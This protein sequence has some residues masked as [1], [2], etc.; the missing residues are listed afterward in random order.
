MRGMKTGNQH[1][2]LMDS[3]FTIPLSIIVPAY[4]EQAGIVGSVRS[5]IGGMQY[6]LYEVIV[7]N[8]GSKDATLQKMIDEFNMEEVSQ[9]VIR[10]RGRLQS[11]KVKA[12]YQSIT[13]PYLL[14]IDKENG[15]KADALNAGINL[16][17]Y[18]Y[19]VSLDGDTVLDYTAFLRII[20]RILEA[21]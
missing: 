12:V 13:Y 10:S 11:K 14:L 19:F 21:E 7:V 2:S 1:E 17:R 18:P 9:K 5:L 15:G 16:S 8:D 20:K 4:N 3:A 6:P